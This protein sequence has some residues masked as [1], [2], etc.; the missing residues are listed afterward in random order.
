APASRANGGTARR[1]R[2]TASPRGG[3][4][5]TPPTGAAA[6]RRGERAQRERARSPALAAT[7]AGLHAGTAAP[8]AFGR[9]APPATANRYRPAVLCLS[10][11][12]PSSASFRRRRRSAGPQAQRPSAAKT[13]ESCARVTP[14]APPSISL[15]VTKK[16]VTVPVVNP[17]HT[18]D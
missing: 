18:L 17:R 7:T 13:L 14:L 1:R 8:R 5:C 15:P 10:T 4:S 9:R 2:C 6:S 16:G 12:A 11:P 3:Q